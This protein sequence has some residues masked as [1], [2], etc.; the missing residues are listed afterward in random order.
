MFERKNQNIDKKLLALFL[1]TFFLFGVFRL[2]MHRHNNITNDRAS[3]WWNK[4]N[5]ETHAPIQREW[6]TEPKKSE[7][8]NLK[9]K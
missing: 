1:P 8:P 4:R 5:V 9:Y 2:P 3:F 7:K 6:E